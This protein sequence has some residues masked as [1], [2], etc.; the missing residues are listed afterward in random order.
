MTLVGHVIIHAHCGAGSNRSQRRALRARVAGAERE[1]CFGKRLC[2]KQAPT[3]NTAHILL[4]TPVGFA[5]LLRSL[6]T[7]CLSTLPRQTAS[8]KAPPVVEVQTGARMEFGDGDRVKVTGKQSTGYDST[9]CP[10][11]S[12]ACTLSPLPTSCAAPCASSGSPSSRRAL[13]WAWSSTTQ[14]ERTTDH[15]RARL[16]SSALPI[17]ASSSGPRTFALSGAAPRRPRMARARAQRP[18]SLGWARLRAAA[19]SPTA[20]TLRRGMSSLGALRSRRSRRT[21]QA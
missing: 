5:V 11:P 15:A 18:P 4:W 20:P 16:T 9:Q 17:T 12:P 1:A 14:R 21:W 3:R 6:P 10:A 13:G 19:R 2:T 8:N 7:R